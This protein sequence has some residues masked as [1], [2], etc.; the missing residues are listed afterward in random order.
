M[1]IFRLLFAFSLISFVSLCIHFFLS[2]FFLSFILIHFTEYEC[3]CVCIPFL[4]LL[5]S[6]LPLV[7]FCLML[8]LPFWTHIIIH[9]KCVVC[10][11]G[12]ICIIYALCTHT[13][14]LHVQPTQI[15]KKRSRN[16]TNQFSVYGVDP[17]RLATLTRFD[18]CLSII[19]DWLM[20]IR[21]SILYH[22]LG[23]VV[24]VV[25]SS[26]LCHSLIMPVFLLSIS[27][28]YSVYSSITHNNTMN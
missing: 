27:V 25:F 24:A 14:V 9:S 18:E 12:C 26:S 20:I 22:F 13:S 28:M 17:K 21:N 23:H 15:A 5:F 6:L 16:T 8:L 19:D 4:L 3:V 10:L 7:H 1:L 11:F 2:F